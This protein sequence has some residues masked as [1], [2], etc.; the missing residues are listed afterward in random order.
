MLLMN[1]RTMLLSP[2]VAAAAAAVPKLRLPHH[3]PILHVTGE[4]SW[5][6]LVE[7]L[8][9]G[10]LCMCMEANAEEGWVTAIDESRLPSRATRRIYGDVVIRC[11]NPKMYEFI[12]VEKLA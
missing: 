5:S 8:L 6:G 9:D 4:D 11:R 12:P 2:L 7:V 10:R 3:S 1:R